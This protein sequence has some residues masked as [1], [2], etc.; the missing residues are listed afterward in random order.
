M[1]SASFAAARPVHGVFQR[2]HV[3]QTTTSDW[4]L[5]WTTDGRSHYALAGSTS[6][7]DVPTC[8]HAIVRRHAMSQ[9]DGN[10][11][12]CCVSS[13]KS[14]NHAAESEL[15][16]N[17]RERGEVRSRRAIALRAI[18]V[19]QTDRRTSV[20]SSRPL[21]VYISL[22]APLRERIDKTSGIASNNK[23]CEMSANKSSRFGKNR[24][25]LF[26]AITN[27]FKYRKTFFLPCCL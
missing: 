19:D 24:K 23:K 16:A 10:S 13:T 14:C 1:S 21:S 26:M 27:I 17:E 12:P 2:C 18:P 8:R 7:D 25:E 3:V 6:V 20:E 11:A 9:D 5:A 4:L 22:E 15:R